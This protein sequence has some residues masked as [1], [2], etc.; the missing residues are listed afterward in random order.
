MLSALTI[1]T[2]VMRTTVPPSMGP[3]GGTISYESVSRWY[4][5]WMPSER[6]E[7]SRP[8][9]LDTVTM[10]NPSSAAGVRNCT[11]LFVTAV[12]RT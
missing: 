4:S 9:L 3:F 6:R 1:S 8:P 7:K 2:P 5:Y 10:I 12:E 11:V